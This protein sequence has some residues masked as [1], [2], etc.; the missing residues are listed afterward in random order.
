[1]SIPET[2]QAFRRS[3]GAL[4]SGTKTLDLVSERIPSSLN[5]Q[6]VLIRIHAIS[7]NYRDLTMINGTY[8]F[9]FM[10]HGV[11]GS[12]CAAEVVA[13]GSEV[14]GF[15]IGDRV[16]VIFDLDN[17]DGTE[18]TRNTLGRDTDGVLRQFAVFDQN[19]LLH[20]PEHL[21][22]EE[23]KSLISSLRFLRL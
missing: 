19:V 12:D 23:V 22:W 6:D 2:Y 9:D 13:T 10:D 1:M 3:T 7:L 14:N 8:P 4:P 20:L 17:I 15:K 16:T 11:P 21:S 5:P 18:E